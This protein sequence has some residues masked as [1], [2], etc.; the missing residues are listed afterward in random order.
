MLEYDFRQDDNFLQIMIRMIENLTACRR[1]NQIFHSCM[2]AVKQFKRK[3]PNEAIFIY[4][5]RTNHN[6]KHMMPYQ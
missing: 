2:S 3:Y 5:N 6:S 1:M 4:M